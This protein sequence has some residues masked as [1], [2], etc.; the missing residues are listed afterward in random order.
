[1]KQVVKPFAIVFWIAAV[2]LSFYA[3]DYNAPLPT[4]TGQK[5]VDQLKSSGQYD[6]LKKAV[7]AVRLK[8]G[9]RSEPKPEDAVGQTAKLIASDGAAGD[10][11]GASVA[12][13]GNVA[14]VGSSFD[15]GGQGSVYIFE[16]TNTTWIAV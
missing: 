12:I 8:D 6:S 7:D 9:R 14:V 13:Q 15:N 2:A 4:L 10:F 1:M 3:Q 5:A 11:F 16:L